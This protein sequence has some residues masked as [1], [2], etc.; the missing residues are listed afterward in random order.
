MARPW[1]NWASKAD[2]AVD[3]VKVDGQVIS[4][5]K[6]HLYVA[7]NKPR[8]VVTTLRDPEGRK[9][10]M[11]FFKGLQERMYPVGRLDYASE[12]L[13]LLDERWRFRERHD[14]ARKQGHENVSGESERHVQLPSRK[15]NSGAAFRYMDGARLPPG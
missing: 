9:T 4:E 15:S 10:V 1:W 3:R 12:G 6:H 2:L 11:S 13:L 8:E 7:F 5:P 14:L